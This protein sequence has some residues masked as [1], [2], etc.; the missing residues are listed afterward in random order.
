MPKEKSITE[1]KDER[2][3]LAARSKEITEGARKESRMLNDAENK[4]L[5]EIQ[6]RMADISMEILQHEDENRGKGKPYSNGEER[7]SLQRALRNYVTR[8]GQ[9]DAEA[10]VIEQAIQTHRNSGAG[11]LTSER[12]LVLPFSVEK[13]ALYTAGTESPKG[14]VIDEDQQEMLF[15]LQP[16]LVLAQAGA[17]FMTGLRGDIYWP[18]FSGVD[19]YW[20]AEN[21][22]ATDAGGEYTKGTV[23]KPLRLTAKVEISEQLLIQE[24]RNVEADIRRQ[25]AVAIA[26]K[27]ESTAFSKAATTANTPDGLFVGGTATSGGAMSWKSIVALEEAADLQNA[28]YGNLA[29]IMHPK[30]VYAAKTTV[31]DASGAG[32]FIFAG[33]GNAELNGYRAFRTNNM[34]SELNTDEYGIVFG[35][36]ADYFIGQWGALELKLDPYTRM[37]EGVI[38]LIVNSYWNMGKVRDES[39]AIYSMK[40]AVAEVTE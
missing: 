12:S 39:F 11:A 20:A 27:L 16:Y 19:V 25:I 7:F 24:N 13:R 30:L 32:G 35:N 9:H 14:V 8:Q 38:R 3:Q 5:G 6:C 26:Q 10:S 21:A 31:K 37:D 28:L 2:K 40:E 17:R 15:P 29:Y 33:N 36:W 23:F 18:K 4:E 22:A 1:L 34:P